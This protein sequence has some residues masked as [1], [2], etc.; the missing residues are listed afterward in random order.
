MSLHL[1]IK[2]TDVELPVW[3]YRRVHVQVWKVAYHRVHYCA[4]LSTNYEHQGLNTKW[5]LQQKGF[6]TAFVLFHERQRKKDNIIQTKQQRE[7]RHKANTGNLKKKINKTC[8]LNVN[9]LTETTIQNEKQTQKK[10][11][12][13]YFIIIWSQ[14]HT[15]RPCFSLPLPAF[16]FFVLYS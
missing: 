6:E 1:Q 2:N 15:C 5:K 10:P 16:H 8:K 14:F 9:R 4:T 7:N 13:M 11:S 12:H 3:I